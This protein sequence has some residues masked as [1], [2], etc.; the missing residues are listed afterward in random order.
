MAKSKK[1]KKKIDAAPTEPGS[2]RSR[3]LVII[4]V[5]A[6]VVICLYLYSFHVELLMGE[7]KSGPLCGADNGLGCHS[8][9]SG[10]CFEK[11]V[12]LFKAGEDITLLLFT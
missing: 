6:S 8:V 5:A 12:K 10:F 4:L 1:V 9:A 7:I 2:K 3:W 11:P